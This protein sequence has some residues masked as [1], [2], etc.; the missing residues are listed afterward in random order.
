MGGGGEGRVG[1]CERTTGGTQKH[2]IK[3]LSLRE[4]TV[5]FAALR[6][7]Y[8]TYSTCTIPST[9]PPKA[10][11][12]VPAFHAMLSRTSNTLPCIFVLAN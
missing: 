2:T 11:T 10:H 3:L 5:P 9:R 1:E 6:C 4:P 8:L 7:T 12:Y